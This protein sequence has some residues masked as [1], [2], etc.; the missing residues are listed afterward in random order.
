MFR[1]LLHGAAASLAIVSLLSAGTSPAMAQAA[2]NE[3]PN[4]AALYEIDVENSE[5]YW[6]VYRAGA[7]SRFGHNHVISVGDLTGNV[8]VQPQIERSQ[9]EIEI[10]AEDLIVD[11]PELRA[12]EG[13]EF[14]SEPTAEDIAGTRSNMLGENVLN[15]E[16]YPVLKVTGSGPS[17][18]Q[19]S[20]VLD[21]TIELLGRSIPVTLPVEVVIGGD[22]L[23]ASGSFSLTHEQLGMEPFSVMMGALQ[24]GE[25]LDFTYRI[26]ARRTD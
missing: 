21:A 17:G 4:D 1:E 12:Q 11:D 2:A 14:A 18:E 6:L 26:T 24:V 13:E 15:A 7:F 3:L 10:A 8:L 20:Q 23:E 22:M 19:G 16:Q 9:F 5:I 25:Q